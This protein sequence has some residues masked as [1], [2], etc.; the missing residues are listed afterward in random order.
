M[1]GK[2]T[3]LKVPTQKLIQE[4]S[5]KEAVEDWTFR[6]FKTSGFRP[7]LL[8]SPRPKPLSLRKNHC[9]KFT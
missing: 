2:L 4:N 8:T 5:N 3:R 1:Q 9:I 6:F 7:L